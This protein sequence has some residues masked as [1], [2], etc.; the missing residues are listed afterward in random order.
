MSI[1]RQENGLTLI[2]ALVLIVIVGILLAMIVPACLRHNLATRLAQNTYRVQV[3]AGEVID[4]ANR[5]SVAPHYAEGD[6]FTTGFGRLLIGKEIGGDVF[7]VAQIPITLANRGDSRAATDQSDASY[8]HAN[9]RELISLGLSN[10][11]GILPKDVSIVALGS[12]VLLRQGTN[13][14]VVR[15]Y[16]T[17][18][19][20]G[21]NQLDFCLQ[22]KSVISENAL[23]AIVRNQ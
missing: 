21:R 3:Q 4:M 6:H 2:E 13:G 19:F 1:K 20:F 12:Y 22:A 11:N 18:S 10:T 16:P 15:L 14:D 17:I 23:Y 9:L 5:L 7:P 8:R